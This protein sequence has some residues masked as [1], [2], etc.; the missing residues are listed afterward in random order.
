MAPRC[1]NAVFAAFNVVTLLLGAAVLA[2][3]IYYGAPH[4]GGGGVT[5]CERFLRAPAL[6]LGGAI[7][8]VSLAGLAGACCHA[9]PL[10]WAYLLLTGLLIL[11]AACFGVFAL[12]VTN[13]GAGRAVSGRGFREYHL[14]DYSTWLRRSVEDGGHWARIRSCL[15]D[16][17]V[18]R[19]L[20]SN[21]TLDE[22]VNSNLSPLQSGCCKPPTACNFTYQNE[23]YWIKPPTPSNY[24]DPDCNS[25]SNDQSELCYGCQSCK[26]GVLGNLRSSWKKIAFVNAAFVALLLV[27]YSLG[28][29]ALRNNRR[30]KYSLVGK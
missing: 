28:C 27:V 22:F 14:G 26:A 18:C 4:R 9:T 10:L 17:G 16:T 1:S 24:S 6:A 11:A 23:T 8:A 13:A 19:S 29:C 5:E 2:A 21:Q 3:G 30:H 20:K 15:V 25:W 12:V 7:V